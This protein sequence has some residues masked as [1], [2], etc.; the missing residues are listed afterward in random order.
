MSYFP[1]NNKWWVLYYGWAIRHDI[2]IKNVLV[3]LSYY[4]LLN[5]MHVIGVKGG[6]MGHETRFTIGFPSSSFI[7]ELGWATIR[8]P[9]IGCLPLRQQRLIL[10]TGYKIY[11]PRKH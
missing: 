6:D 2:K 1:N 10:Q 11:K 5:D 7:I 8:F 3:F 4:L 9:A